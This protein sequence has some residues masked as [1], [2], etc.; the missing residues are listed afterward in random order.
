MVLAK[1]FLGGEYY[2]N[3]CDLDICSVRLDFDTFQLQDPAA[4]TG[5]CTDT[6]TVTSPTEQPLPVVCGTLTG[7]HS[8]DI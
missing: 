3:L 4:N 6:L 8:K 1:S 5:S 2:S 7:Q